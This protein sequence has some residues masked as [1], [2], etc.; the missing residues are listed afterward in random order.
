VTTEEL[1][2]RN[3]DAWRAATAHPFLE[4]VRTG[5]LSP[6]AFATWLA[7]DRLFVED[8]LRFQAALLARS[9]R[10]AQ[11]VLAG[12]LVALESELTWFE[13]QAS[14]RRLDLTNDRHPTTAAYQGHMLALGGAPFA[15]ALVSLWALERAYLDAWSSARP[16]AAAY[17]EFVDHWTV[18]EF[19]TYVDGLASAADRALADEPS[20]DVTAAFLETLRLE[21]AFWDMSIRQ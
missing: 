10:F 13:E 21:R 14:T 18:P 2:S 16:G 11:A 4:G 15:A 9:P 5:S 7:Q 20:V 17:R 8:L 12:G 1:A 6:G 3:A 19:A